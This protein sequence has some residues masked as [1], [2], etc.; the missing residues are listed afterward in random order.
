MWR[1][2]RRSGRLQSNISVSAGPTPRNSVRAKRGES[3]VLDSESSS[4]DDSITPRYR[5]R[6]RSKH[7]R[8]VTNLEDESQRRPTPH[9]PE[10][11][12]G[13]SRKSESRPS[14]HKRAESEHFGNR[15]GRTYSGSNRYDDS[16]TSSSSDSSESS[17]GKH[18]GHRSRDSRFGRNHI[19]YFSELDALQPGG[20]LHRPESSRA[21]IRESLRADV[22]PIEIDS[23]TTWESV[24]GLDDHLS[25]LREMVQLPLLYPELFERFQLQPPKGVLFYGPP[26]TGKT[27]VARALASSCSS[28]PNSKPI[29][30]F[31][32]KGADCLSKWVGE[33][34][35]QLRLLFEEGNFLHFILTL[36]H[37]SPLASGS[38]PHFSKA[39]SSE[40]HIL[41]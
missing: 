2:P 25:S 23:S 8:S 37:A 13:A 1:Q 22:A 26:G 31:M 6:D 36:S 35:K 14:G 41:R 10:R 16:S 17:R 32:R 20:A 7:K 39:A 18:R 11:R 34:E 40:H 33:A 21:G 19:D 15:P 27:L 4:E 24:G 9:L 29:S 28:I 30:F 12:P 3:K 38:P 5:F